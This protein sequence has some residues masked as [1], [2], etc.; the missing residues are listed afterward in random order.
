MR[1]LTSALISEGVTDDQFLPR[2]LGR[3]LTELCCT[4]FDDPVEVADVQPLRDR[5][6]PSG[7]PD[8]IRLVERNQAS[9]SIIFFHHDQGTSIE[10]VEDEWLRPLRRAWGERP[11]RLVTVVPVRETEAWLLADGEGLRRALGVRWTDTAM[12]LPSHPKDVERI[13]DPK[14][15]LNQVLARVSRSIGD[16]YGQL[17]ELVSLDRLRLVPAYQKWWADTRKALTDLGYR[18]AGGYPKQSGGSAR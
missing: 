14:Q 3:A 11:E 2:L 7:L 4:E 5:K 18:P 16:H 15:V 9:F 13:E 1:Y 8:V 10:R 6:G 17:G 12:G